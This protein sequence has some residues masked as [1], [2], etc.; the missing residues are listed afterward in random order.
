MDFHTYFFNAFSASLSSRMP[1]K[2][3]YVALGF[4]LCKSLCQSCVFP[5]PVILSAGF[6]CNSDGFLFVGDCDEDE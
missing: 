6:K 2:F 5:S 3:M 1:R 4:V